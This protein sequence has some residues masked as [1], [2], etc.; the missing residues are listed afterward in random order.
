[1]ILKNK[2][3]KVLQFIAH[4]LLLALSLSLLASLFSCKANRIISTETSTTT[5]TPVEVAP[6]SFRIDTVEIDK[7][8]YLTKYDTVVKDSIRVKYIRLADGSSQ[9]DVDCPDYKETITTLEKKLDLSKESK[10]EIQVKAERKALKQIEKA[11]Q[12]HY[13]E[14][15]KDGKKEGRRAGRRDV[16]I[17]LAVLVGIYVFIKF[18]TKLPI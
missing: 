2:I 15:L 6:Q 14:G 9:V 18:R 16:L 1:M 4:I 17:G 11:R 13:K 10:A 8:V 12:Q 5:E 7:P 3:T